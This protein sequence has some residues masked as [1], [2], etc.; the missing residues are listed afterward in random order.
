MAVK[1]NPIN[2]LNGKGFPTT[3]NPH[4]YYESYNPNRGKK[5][6]GKRDLMEYGVNADGYCGGYHKAFDMSKSHG[7]GIPSIANALVAPGTGWNTFGWTLVLTFFDATG[8]HYQVIYGHLN[9]NPL[10][11]LKVGQKVKKGEIVAYQGRSN[12]IGVDNMASHLHIQF[13][14]FGALDAKGFTCNGIDPLNIN[15]SKTHATRPPSTKT[16]SKKT[17]AKKKNGKVIALDIGHGKNTFPSRGKGVFKNGKG[18]AEFS[19]NNKLAKRIKALL[20]HNGFEVIM[21][22]PFDGNDV[23]LIQRTNYYDSKRPDLGISVHA[24][25]GA[26]NVGGRCAFYWNTSKQGKKFATNI[27]NNMKDMEYGV[28]GSGL[29]ASQYNSWTNLHMIRECTT[30]PMVLVEHGFMTNALDFPLIFGNRQDE[31]V[32]DMANADVKATC[33]YF[34]FSFAELGAQTTPSAPAAVASKGGVY[35]RVQ[36]G[37]FGEKTNAINLRNK[38]NA[39]GYDTLLAYDNEDDLYRIQIG[40]FSKKGNAEKQLADVKADGFKDAFIAGNDGHVASSETTAPGEPKTPRI[41]GDWDENQY[42]TQ[43]VAAEGTFTVGGSRIMSREGSPF[44]SGRNQ[45]PEGGWA[46]PGY[47]IEYD[48]LVRW[49]ESPTKGY[50]GIGYNQNGKRWYLPYNTWNPRTGAVGEEAWGGF[51]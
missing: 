39:K 19:F 50:V 21:A 42:G 18:Y 16:V 27:V 44:F 29:H 26:S 31:Y 37:A 6:F 30:F 14:P 20:E 36:V 12:N 13:Q 49:A 45:A 22:Q 3:S 40:A 41:I 33:E 5:P 15:V 34:G 17:K 23:G 48:E 4:E 32:E 35:Y 38:V 46:N 25:A 28:H 43:Y 24:N 47:S 10:D 9:R 2:Y 1:N 8:K 11:Y 7:A 51:S